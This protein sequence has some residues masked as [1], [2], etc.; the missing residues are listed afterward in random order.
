MPHRVRD[1]LVGLVLLSFTLR[2][3]L[4]ALISPIAYASDATLKVGC[5]V[6]T[7]VSTP[8]RVWLWSRTPR[9]HDPVFLGDDG[10]GG[11]QRWSISKFGNL[12]TSYVFRRSA[13]VNIQ[14]GLAWR[15][16]L[17]YAALLL[18]TTIRWASICAAPA[19]TWWVLTPR[20]PRPRAALV[21]PH[22]TSKLHFKETM[23]AKTYSARRPEIWSKNQKISFCP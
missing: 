9:R 19:G 6:S 23:G 2:S 1:E 21:R 18:W 8:E 14:E 13:H 7:P 4:T 10:G 3:D 12:R 16:A 20:C 17:R 5:V 22:L 11:H 15:S